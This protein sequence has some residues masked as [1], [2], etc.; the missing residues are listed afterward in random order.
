MNSIQFTINFLYLHPTH[1]LRYVVHKCKWFLVR[2]EF[3]FLIAAEFQ[4]KYVDFLIIFFIQNAQYIFILFSNSS[5]YFCVY[6]LDE[7]LNK[8][9]PKH[10]FLLVPINNTTTL[11]FNAR[12]STIY[13]HNSTTFM[14]HRVARFPHIFQRT[15]LYKYLFF[16]FVFV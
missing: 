2:I 15:S 1:L 7:N 4:C 6:I 10:S 5:A 11:L 14:Q 13:R 16:L 3:L 9:E 8:T 12:F